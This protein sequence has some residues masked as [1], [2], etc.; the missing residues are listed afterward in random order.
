M[1]F[2]TVPETWGEFRRR[3]TYNAARVASLIGR[4]LGP[5]VL[6][7]GKKR[8][9]D[10]VASYLSTPKRAK[11]AVVPYSPPSDPLP[12]SQLT[13]T[14]VPH[15]SQLSDISSVA[16]RSRASMPGY[17]SKP[18]RAP[19]RKVVSKFPVSIKAEHAGIVTAPTTDAVY[20]GHGC[21]YRRLLYAI[22]FAVVERLLKKMGVTIADW[23]DVTHQTLML[24]LYYKPSGLAAVET[25]FSSPA[26]A[27]TATYQDVASELY[28]YLQKF[29][30]NTGTGSLGQ[31]YA[32]WHKIA[33]RTGD[34]NG[35]VTTYFHE[36]TMELT[37]LVVDVSFS[38]NLKI[39]NITTGDAATD[40]QAEDVTNNPLQGRVYSGSGN[41]P[42]YKRIG[43]TPGPTTALAVAHGD[44]GVITLDR[45]GLT[46]SALENLRRP[47][48]KNMMGN[49][50]RYSSVHLQPGQIRPDYVKGYKSMYFNA[51]M[52]VLHTAM[53][54]TPTAGQVQQ[55]RMN[56]FG[57]HLFGFEKMV[58]TG[59]T[60][61][62][63]GYEVDQKYSAK[64]KEK[65]M[66]AAA[67][68]FIT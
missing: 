65:W 34:D 45:T 41:G 63:V 2:Y 9:A 24:T 13:D 60:P 16:V 19:K 27:S 43:G 18:F 20:I 64:V 23:R 26:V 39:Q 15:Y 36:A 1:Q 29:Y 62:E 56:V 17:Y 11:R 61:A 37:T 52:R 21:A 44:T 5:V 6:S 3:H 8:V 35:S 30:A 10:A 33:L 51:W 31:V 14:S 55:I 54:L 28:D 53:F 40:D 66:P 68:Q 32:E 4:E 50:S 47:F 7:Y 57:Y 38:S 58:R 67:L 59:T 22:S 25:S 12:A 48:D 49:V 42:Y 46:G